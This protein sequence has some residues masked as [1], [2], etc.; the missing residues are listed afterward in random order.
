MVPH[1]RLMVQ[2]KATISAIHVENK[3]AYYGDSLMW[4][5]PYNM[6]SALEENLHMLECKLGIDIHI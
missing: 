4:P 3:S 1:L 6:I 2:C 5:V